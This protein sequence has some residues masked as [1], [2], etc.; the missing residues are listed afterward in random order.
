MDLEEQQL[1]YFGAPPP[2]YSAKYSNVPSQPL[3]SASDST[4]SKLGR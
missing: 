1:D 4:L 3:A 2:K